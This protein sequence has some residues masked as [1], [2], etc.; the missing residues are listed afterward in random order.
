MSTFTDT[1]RMTIAIE[2]FEAV[3]APLPADQREALDATATLDFESW[4][5]FGEFPVR[6]QMAGHIDLSESL[7]LHTIHT[8]F[9]ST[10]TLAE[11]L[12]FMEMVALYGDKC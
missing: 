1:N 7:V 3:L 6:M 11:R 2:K 12:V 10:A 4:F 9:R 8:N 5:A